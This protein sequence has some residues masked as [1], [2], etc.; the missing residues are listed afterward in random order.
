MAAFRP[1]DPQ[2][3]LTRSTGGISLSLPGVPEQFENGYNCATSEGEEAGSINYLQT[4]KISVFAPAPEPLWPLKYLYVIVRQLI[5]FFLPC[6]YNF[7]YNFIG[8]IVST[9][10]HLL[11]IQAFTFYLTPCV[12]YSSTVSI[13]LF[14]HTQAPRWAPSVLSGPTYSSALGGRVRI[15][16]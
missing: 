16:K 14:F 3:R 9:L 10:P 8:D 13:P 2:F 1:Q 4:L 11:F 5:S 15:E 12:S 6:S 7:L